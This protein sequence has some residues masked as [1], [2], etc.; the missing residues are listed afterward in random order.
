MIMLAAAIGLW[1]GIGIGFV[2]GA[3]W[4]NVGRSPTMTRGMTENR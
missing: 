1:I 4:C 2:A 3:S